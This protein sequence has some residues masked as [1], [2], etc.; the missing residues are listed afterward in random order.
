MVREVILEQILL[1]FHCSK[2]LGV[3]PTF[4]HVIDEGKKSTSNT[5]LTCFEMS[6]CGAVESVEPAE[7]YNFALFSDMLDHAQLKSSPSCFVACCFAPGLPRTCR[8]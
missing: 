3:L 2:R 6:W 5:S 4:V 1:N 8:L 7:L